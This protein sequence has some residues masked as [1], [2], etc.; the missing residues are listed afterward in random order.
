[1]AISYLL[2]NFCLLCFLRNS[3]CEKFHS[4]LYRQIEIIES[5]YDGQKKCGEHRPIETTFGC[6]LQR[7]TTACMAATVDPLAIIFIHWHLHSSYSRW[8]CIADVFVRC[9][10]RA[11]YLD[12]SGECNTRRESRKSIVWNDYTKRTDWLPNSIGKFDKIHHIRMQIAA[13]SFGTTALNGF[14][15]SI[16]A[17]VCD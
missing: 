15:F 6:C 11:N 2:K 1:M 9:I 13:L 12:A 4:I 14:V 3:I 8:R 10:A 17:V 16:K 5:K 7:I